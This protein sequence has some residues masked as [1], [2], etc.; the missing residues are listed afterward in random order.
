MKNEKEASVLSTTQYSEDDLTLYNDKAIKVKKHNVNKKIFNKKP[1]YIESLS[2]SSDSNQFGLISYDPNTLDIDLNLRTSSIASEAEVVLDYASSSERFQAL[3]AQYDFECNYAKSTS[4]IQAVADILKSKKIA[5]FLKE[6]LIILTSFLGTYEEKCKLAENATYTDQ[7]NINYSYGS[8]C[9]KLH[10]TETLGTA[11]IE[12]GCNT[13]NLCLY[14]EISNYDICKP[15]EV[16]ESHEYLSQVDNNNFNITYNTQP[17]DQYASSSCSNHN[18]S[19]ISSACYSNTSTIN[20]SNMSYS[21]VYPIKDLNKNYEEVC[22]R[23]LYQ[24]SSIINRKTFSRNALKK[25]KKINMMLRSNLIRT[26]SS[27]T[28]RHFQKHKRKFQRFQ[29]AQEV[30]PER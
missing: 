22:T 14:K 18:I 8:S 23:T 12:D 24:L 19:M 27:N 4:E 13:K 15:V 30:L 1:S 21:T 2:F 3:D 6:M 11:Y 29:F 28:F 10:T 20:Y 5:K 26:C 25:K 7:E 9:N 17:E 16:E